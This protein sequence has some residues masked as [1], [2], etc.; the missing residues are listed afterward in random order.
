MGRDTPD[1]LYYLCDM[2]SELGEATRYLQRRVKSQTARVYLDKAQILLLQ[3][4][5]F[6]EQAEDLE[7]NYEKEGRTC[8]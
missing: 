5:S 8:P 4:A 3:A 1:K 7:R 6:I 2:V